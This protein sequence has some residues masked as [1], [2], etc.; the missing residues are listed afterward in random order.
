MFDWSPRRKGKER[1]K[2]RKEREIVK[3]MMEINF[4][5]QTDE[6]PWVERAC[7]SSRDRKQR[8]TSA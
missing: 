5:K 8:K 3:E 2:N 1:K 7:W 6:R 4:P